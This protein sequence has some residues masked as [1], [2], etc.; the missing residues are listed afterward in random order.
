MSVRLAVDRPAQPP[1][2]VVRAELLAANTLAW[3]A[4]AR[5]D[6]LSIDAHVYLFERY[7]RLADHH[8]RRGHERRAERLQR[9]ADAHREYFDDGDPPAAAAM[10]MPR[11]RPWVVTD[12]ISRPRLP[13]RPCVK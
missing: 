13:S 2:V 7:Q 8:R 4:D 5:G 12:A 1:L 11:P 6:E 9:K 3:L 10:A